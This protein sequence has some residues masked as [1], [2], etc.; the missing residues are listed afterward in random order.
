MLER[1]PLRLFMEW[2]AYYKL[3][4]W[5]EERAD[6]S[7][8]IIATVVANANRGKG[9]AYKVSDFMPQFDK[10]TKRQ[11]PEQMQTI[12]RAMAGAVAAKEQLKK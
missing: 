10:Q 2:A 8:A 3:S 9:K 4:P 12:L 7:R 6:F 11:T 1:I 5:G